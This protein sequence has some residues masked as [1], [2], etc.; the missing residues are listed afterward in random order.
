[1]HCDHAT[2]SFRVFWQNQVDIVKQY[3]DLG[4]RNPTQWT[5]V[6]AYKNEFTSGRDFVLGTDTVMILERGKPMPR[7][8]PRETPLSNHNV[9]FVTEAPHG[10]KDIGGRKVNAAF[11]SWQGIH[12]WTLMYGPGEG[13]VL[14]AL[15]G[16]GSVIQAMILLDKYSVVAVEKDREIFDVAVSNV[17]KWLAKV[18][19]QVR[20]STIRRM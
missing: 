17:S 7:E 20:M 1:M 2:L 3:T 13:W 12:D 14:S 15:D 9:V 5:F 11:K 4:W 8:T 16:L 19:E 10:A 6:N 18:Q